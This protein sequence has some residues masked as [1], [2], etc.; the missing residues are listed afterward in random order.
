MNRLTNHPAVVIRRLR[1]GVERPAVALRT[2]RALEPRWLRETL[3]NEMHR[4]APPRKLDL[5]QAA[6]DLSA[7]S[8]EA[9]TPAPDW[10]RAEPISP[11]EA[12]AVR[13]PGVPEDATPAPLAAV[14]AVE[15]NGPQE[16][17]EAQLGGELCRAV[18]AAQHDPAP[19]D[20]I[21][22]ALLSA[23]PSCA[24]RRLIVAAT[25]AVTE[26]RR[27]H[28]GQTPPAVQQILTDLAET[29]ND[30]D[31]RAFVLAAIM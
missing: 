2:P 8:S 16:P 22:A 1:F 14:L 20:P 4:R 23:M 25:Y 7:S 17:G 15:L 9:D 10:R 28:G 21:A 13:E 6:L 5:L 27:L 11:P 3:T 30:D 18:T 31:I 29:T 24:Q 26:V 19:T 12:P